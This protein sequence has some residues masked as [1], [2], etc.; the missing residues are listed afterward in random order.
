M[1]HGLA[2]LHTAAVHEQTFARLC[3]E[4]APALKVRHVVDESLLDDAR[5]R[6]LDGP[7]ARRVHAAVMAAAATGAAVVACTCSTIGGLAEA[8][9]TAGKFTAMRID[10][11]MADIA[12]AA[13]GRILVIAALASTLEPTRELLRS[14]AQRAAVR[15]TI[16][17]ALVEEAWTSFARG[18]LDRYHAMAAGAVQDNLGAADVI[19]LAQASMAAVA[20]RFSG[21]PVLVLASPRTGVTAAVRL[22]GLRGTTPGGPGSKRDVASR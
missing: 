4:I 1:R 11:A 2:F 7:L 3:Q 8:T 5:A 6:G 21:A 10:R 15:V 16:A 13:G 9:N 14:S 18:D 12:V 19:V 22:L 20:D 17:E